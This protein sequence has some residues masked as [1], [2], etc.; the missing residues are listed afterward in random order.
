MGF[1]TLLGAGKPPSSAGVVTLGWNAADKTAAIA[2][3]AG[4]SN[5]IANTDASF[6]AAGIRSATSHSAGKWY[7]E[8][9]IGNN[10]NIQDEV[11]VMDGAGNLASV[12]GGATGWSYVAHGAY[13]HS[14]SQTGSPPSYT[15]GDVV[16][17]AVDFAVGI[18]FAKNNTFVG[19]PSAGTGATFAGLSG[20]LF[21]ATSVLASAAIK[22]LTLQ[23]VL[24][25][26]PPTGFTAWG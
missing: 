2:S 1:M 16:G 14:N 13:N 19:S 20:T 6:G 3:V 25:Y 26:A 11:G 5:E 10:R 18:W 12:G 9:V 22:T 7:F 15:D 21:A 8:F 24:T 17:V 4:T 23:K